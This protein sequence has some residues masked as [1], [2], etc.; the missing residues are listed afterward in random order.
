MKPPLN[1]R[2]LSPKTGKKNPEFENVIKN[3]ER[4]TISGYEQMTQSIGGCTN[5]RVER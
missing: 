1:P 3:E 5:D 2:N 4:H